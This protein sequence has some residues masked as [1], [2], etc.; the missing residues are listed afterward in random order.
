VGVGDKAEVAAAVVG[1]TVTLAAGLQE[2]AAPGT[3]LCSGTTAHLAQAEVD[4]EAVGP[5]PGG[6]HSTPVMVYKVLGR[7][8]PQVLVAPHETRPWSRFVGRSRELGTLLALLDQVEEGHGHV[9][10]IMGDPGIGK[11][12]LLDEFRQ[13]LTGRRLTYLRGRCLSYGSATPYLPVLDLLRHRCGM[14]EV[15]SPEIMTTKVRRGLQEVG[16]VAEEWAPYCMQLLGLEPGAEALTRLSPQAIKARTFEALVQLS[17]HSSRQR[18]LVI[19]VEDLHWIDATSEDWLA[20][21]VER[22]AGVPILV[23]VSYRPG[24][25]TPWVDKSY[26]TQLT[27]RQLTPSDSR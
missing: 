13:R 25:R 16:I 26:A 12:R 14:T 19:E 11:S 9:V 22:V 10:G 20:T 6:G 8:L 24:Y 3:I 2:R 4:V 21:L 23:L 17:I 7:R 18:P 15:D 1:D 5:M 27:L